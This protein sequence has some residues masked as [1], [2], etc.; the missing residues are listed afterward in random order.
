M[1]NPYARITAAGTFVLAVLGTAWAPAQA[2]DVG[3]SLSFAQPGAY[4]RVDIGSL[5]PPVL[6]APRP[7]VIGPR[8]AAEPVYLWVPDHERM[9]WG[10][11]CSRYRACGMPV[12]FVQD[13][14]YRD[15]VIAERRHERRVD[16][17][18]DRREDR[19]EERRE[20]RREDRRG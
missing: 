11:Y 2:A 15:H 7:V 13:R 19:R 3:V 14:W 9:N 16:R 20:D 1:K 18:Q 6:W 5:P 10:R 17:R 12:Y 8:I 4:G